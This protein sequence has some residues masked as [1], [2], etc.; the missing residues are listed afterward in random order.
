MYLRE[1]TKYE[2]TPRTQGLIDVIDCFKCIPDTPKLA[3]PKL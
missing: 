1:K 2:Y 3:P